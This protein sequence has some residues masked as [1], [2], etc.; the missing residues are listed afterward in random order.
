[1]LIYASLHEKPNL[2]RQKLVL[3]EYIFVADSMGVFVFT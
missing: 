3:A 2:Y 1:M